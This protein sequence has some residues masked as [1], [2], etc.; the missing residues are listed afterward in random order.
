[1]AAGAGPLAPHWTP[2]MPD[3]T[4]RFLPRRLPLFL[5][6]ALLPCLISNSCASS[7]SA[8]M[9]HAGRGISPAAEASYQFLVYQDL[10]RQGRKE[11]AAQILAGLAA[12]HPSPEVAVELANLQWG[13]NEREKATETLEQ[14][15]RAFPASRQLSFY[16]ANA[17][18]MRRMGGMAIQTLERFLEQ[19]PKDVAGIQELASLLED[20][21]KHAEAAALLERIPE[22]DRDATAWFLMA[23]ASAA[24]S[25]PKEAIRQLREALAKDQSL[26]AAW[27]DLGMLLDQTGDIKGAEECYQKM[28]ALGEDSSEVRSKLL[29]LALK[30]KNPAKAMKLL[31]DAPS[32]KALLLDAMAALVET[33]Y[34]AQ[35]KQVF[36][37]LE[38]L[39]PASPDLVFYK[40]VLA[41][42]GDKNPR[43]AMD[44][45]GQVPQDSPNY[46]KSLSFRIQ[47]ATEIGDLARARA[48]SREGR[49][50]FPDKKEFVILESALLD[51]VGETAAAA[52]VLEQATQTWP[53]DLDILY[54]H[55]VVLEKLKRRDEAK[56]VM[57]RIVLKDPANP[58]ALNYLGYSLAEEGR[59]LERAL[60]MIRTALE[61]DPD[62]PFFLDSLAWALHKLNRHEEALATIEQ[63]IAH[64]VKDAIIWEHYGDIAAAAGR[65]ATAQK[66]YRKALELG[67]ESPEAVKKKLGAL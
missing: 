19:N 36:S 49:E 15:L 45:L 40:A 33:G 34:P 13:Q 22:G 16:L 58:D 11:E 30:Q 25:R 60:T 21:G 42:E 53:D 8:F 1:M 41:Y 14:A 55:G 59:D 43:A 7:R 67:S 48:L 29:R 56:A 18:Q 51:K 3:A 66:A 4:K 32:D 23:K 57:E 12:N 24:R 50:R 65:K 44:I 52:R 62:N 20:S 5:V 64:K 39:D 2:A 38:A 31:K 10:L 6:L 61:K 37:R 54:R 17:Y 27:L 28:L 26:M 63:A 9:A 35:A 47:I 46:D